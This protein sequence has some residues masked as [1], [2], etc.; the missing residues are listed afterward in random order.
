MTEEKQRNRFYDT[1]EWRD[2]RKY[3]LERE[4]VCRMRCGR[5]ATMVDHIVRLEDGGAPFDTANLQPLCDSCHNSKRGK[6]AKPQV[7]AGQKRFTCGVMVVFGPPGAM[8]RQWALDHR[9]S[10]DLVID[11]EELGRAISGSVRKDFPFELLEPLRDITGALTEMLYRPNLPFKKAWLIT[12]SLSKSDRELLHRAGAIMHCLIQPTDV[13]AQNL[14][15]FYN[16]PAEE[17]E[18]RVKFWVDNYQEA[19]CDQPVYPA[20]GEGNAPLL[21]RIK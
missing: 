13:C 15:R 6:E 7:K 12:E 19:G 9:A 4:P 21:R 3:I 5:M 17:A 16:L 10:G 8:L 18:Q 20:S 14:V 1:K 2:C 11:R